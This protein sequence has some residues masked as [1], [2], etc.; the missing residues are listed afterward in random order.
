LVGI[1]GN[2][3]TLLSAYPISI[4]L[5]G[6]K[7]KNSDVA[8]TMNDIE[9]NLQSGVR[10]AKENNHNKSESLLRRA[11]TGQASG[12]CDKLV[13]RGIKGRANLLQKLLTRAAAGSESKKNSSGKDARTTKSSKNK[14]SI[15]QGDVI[16]KTKALNG[17]DSNIRSVNDVV[18]GEAM[19]D[20]SYD[21]LDVMDDDNLKNSKMSENQLYLQFSGTAT[22]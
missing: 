21:I 10:S 18:L 14:F 5:D 22:K 2:D 8:L 3:A 9:V 4:S 1:A 6:N 15:D 20:E 16:L 17:K 12:Y 11:P 13:A 7:Y 19:L